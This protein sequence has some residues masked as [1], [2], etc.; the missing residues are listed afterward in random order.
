MISDFKNY[1]GSKKLHLAL[2]GPRNGCVATALTTGG[3]V[4][5][6]NKW[7]P[8]RAI[9]TK[10][11]LS[12]LAKRVAASSSPPKCQECHCLKGDAR[13]V[14]TCFKCFGNSAFLITH[15]D[16]EESK[17]AKVSLLTELN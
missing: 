5:D 11:F 8:K 7:T 6:S 12:V 14:P 16:S 10:K 1:Q 9:Q 4:F 13:T 3:S 17:A 15:T 2:R